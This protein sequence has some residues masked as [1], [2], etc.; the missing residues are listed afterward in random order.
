[1]M[2]LMPIGMPSIGESG[3]PLAPARGR[4]SAACAGRLEV[5]GDEGADLRLPGL[6]RGEAALEEIA[7]RI[8]AAG[9]IRG[10]REIGPHDRGLDVGR[11]HDLG[12][13]S[14]PSPSSEEGRGGAHGH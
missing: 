1:M 7:R 5:E 11:V 9:E 10:R 6:E 14:S 12:R 3:L 13:C 2:S 8:L 4:R